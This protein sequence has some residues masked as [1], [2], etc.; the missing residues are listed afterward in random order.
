MDGNHLPKISEVWYDLNTASI[1]RTRKSKREYGNDTWRDGMG[2]MVFEMP[3]TINFDYTEICDKFSENNM[4]QQ[5]EA[6]N[7]ISESTYIIQFVSG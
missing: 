3:I 2:Q 4:I 6:Q 1:Q 5:N 7:G